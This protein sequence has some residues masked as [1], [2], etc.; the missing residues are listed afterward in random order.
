MSYY[1][2][3][4]VKNAIGQMVLFYKANAD[5][6]W[7]MVSGKTVPSAVHASQTFGK[8]IF[9][10]ESEEELANIPKE[11]MP[12]VM[13]PERICIFCGKYGKNA[14]FINM[15]TVYLCD[16]DYQNKSTGQVG[17]KMKELVNN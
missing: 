14:K 15:Q 17:S 8:A 1:K 13:H 11:E 7:K 10:P 4:N 12:K 2:K 9:V 3:L 6:K 5:F 16:E